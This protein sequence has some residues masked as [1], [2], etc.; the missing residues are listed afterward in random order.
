MWLFF[1]S[2]AL[3]T[4]HHDG[5]DFPVVG[6]TYPYVDVDVDQVHISLTDVLKVGRDAP[7]VVC[8][9][10]AHRT[11]GPLRIDEARPA[12][13]APAI[14]GALGLRER[15]CWRCLQVSTPPRWS[16]CISSR[17]ATSVW[18]VSV[19]FPGLYKSS[20]LHYYAVEC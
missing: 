14:R 11:A 17:H 4:P 20:V 2:S 9:R 12:V 5:A 7:L 1:V 10:R 8:L 13:P 15:E 19:A 18:S 6:C 16:P 3:R